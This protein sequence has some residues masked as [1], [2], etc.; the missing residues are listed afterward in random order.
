MF[1]AKGVEGKAMGGEKKKSLWVGE[2]KKTRCFKTTTKL[3]CLK[4]RRTREG[5]G[6]RQKI[7][8]QGVSRGS[9]GQKIIRTGRRGEGSVSER[10]RERNRRI[11]QN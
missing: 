9:K 4:R 8:R 7:K 1:E 3:M 5:I 11:W 2:G 10:Q 6:R